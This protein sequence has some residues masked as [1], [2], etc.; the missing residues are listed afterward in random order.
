VNINEQLCDSR[1]TQKEHPK[2]IHAGAQI[3]GLVSDAGNLIKKGNRGT[4]HLHSFRCITLAETQ[5]F[6][7]SIQANFIWVSTC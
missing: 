7:I 1:E 4:T 6:L 3:R 5:P 2:G